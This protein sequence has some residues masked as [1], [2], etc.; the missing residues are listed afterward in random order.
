MALKMYIVVRESAPSH[1]CVAIA[2][3]V[4]MAH[5]KFNDPLFVGHEFYAD[6]LKNSFRKVVCE[7]GDI[8]FEDLKF[9]GNHVVVT[10]SGLSGMEIALVFCPRPE[11]PDEFRQ[12]PM[13]K[14]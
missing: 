1:K 4:L 8:Q 14:I 13:M 2:H 10:E 6:W 3:G 9:H 12:L 7:A 11:W 5:L